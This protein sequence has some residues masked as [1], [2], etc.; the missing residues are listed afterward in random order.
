MQPARLDGFCRFGGLKATKTVQ[1]MALA[2]VLALDL[3]QVQ[4]QG[5]VQ[6]Y[7]QTWARSQHREM[8]RAAVKRGERP[9]RHPATSGTFALVCPTARATQ[10]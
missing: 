6:R 5:Q 10:C 2:L 1:S 8:V 3:A 7:E 9:R 4:V